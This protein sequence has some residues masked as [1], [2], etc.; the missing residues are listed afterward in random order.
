MKDPNLVEEGEKPKN[1]RRVKIIVGGKIFE[2]TVSTLTRLD[3]TVDGESFALPSDRDARESLR[4]EAEFYNLPG[5]AKM[6]SP[7]LH[8]GDCVQ[9]KD[10]AI[11]VYWKW[12][13]R[14]EYNGRKTCP[15]ANCETCG[16]QVCSCAGCKAL[17]SNASAINYDDWMSVK[18]QMRFMKGYV[19][20]IGSKNC[21]TVEWDNGWRNHGPQ[22][23]H[24][25][26]TFE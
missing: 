18:H 26:A 22:S 6:C 17:S 23:A 4:R 10:S 14:F 7:G 25:L 12:F 19:I 3:D 8:V 20:K 21:C 1:N 2:T 9:W 11:E 24:R 15:C 16:C 5:L 13:A